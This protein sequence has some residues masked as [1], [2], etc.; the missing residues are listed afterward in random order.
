MACHS[1]GASLSTWD[2]WSRGGSKYTEGEPES[3]WA[4]FEGAGVGF[5]TVVKMATDANAGKN[6]IIAEKNQRQPVKVTADDFD[7]VVEDEPAAKKKEDQSI[8]FHKG[9]YHMLDSE[10]MRYIEMGSEDLTRQLRLQGYSMKDSNGQ[11]S[12]VDKV[13]ANI[14]M[15]NTVDHIGALAGRSVGL[16]R[17]DTSGTKHLI[18]RK[19]NRVIAKA[20]DC[21]NT[22]AILQAQYGD[23][24]PYILSWLNR[25]RL[26]LS[27]EQFMQG[28]V[29]I[30]AGKPDGGKSLVASLVFKPL[31]GQVAKA[32]L[33]LAKG[34]DFNAD[35]VGSELLLLDDEKLSM[36]M[37]DRRGFGLKLK[38]VC[39]GSGNV[40]RHGKGAD[41]YN[42]NPLWRIVILINDNDTDLGCLPPLGEGEDDSIG[43]KVLLLKCHK[44]PL[45]FE[46]DAD[47]P[48]K[49]AALFKKEEQAFAHYVDNYEIP[50]S[51]RTGSSRF[52]F[53]HYH[54]R[55][56]VQTLNANSNERTLLSATYDLIFRSEHSII[57]LLEDIS[58]GR[59]YWKG[60]ALEWAN[61]LRS[62]KRHDAHGI[63]AGALA[64]GDTAVKAGIQLRKVAE[65]SDGR[66]MKDRDTT[67]RLWTIY[68]PEEMDTVVADPDLF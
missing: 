47:Q 58:S 23:Q 10:G 32:G 42:V 5:G 67:S 68:Q 19:N 49:L 8:Y 59:K 11:M 17:D 31:L 52:G 37:E 65:V 29:L 40:S 55:D 2:T 63:I 4:S 36:R 64:Y 12:A 62:E 61:I 54:H 6:P 50:A 28:H 38:S 43:D 45:P 9:K 3:K 30:I 44:K 15:N 35:L 51:I 46:G 24:L 27:T 39:A 21:S 57:P 53:E 25:A 18:T 14:V 33:Y 26:Q 22:L 60:T 20:G 48:I 41:A 16:H 7:D 56:L 34:N 1:H 66:V 13:K